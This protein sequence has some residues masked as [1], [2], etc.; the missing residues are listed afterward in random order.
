M[1]T[2]FEFLPF[3]TLVGGTVGGYITFA[4]GHRLID[5]KITGKEN[6]REITK[7]SVTCYNN[8]IIDENTSFR[9]GSWSCC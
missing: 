9:C 5:A 7:S 3:V 4:G 1:P 2:G 8:S 6:L